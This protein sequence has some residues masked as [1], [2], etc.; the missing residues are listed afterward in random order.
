MR[1][2]RNIGIRPSKS[3][4]HSSS[5]QMSTNLKPSK[6]I[7]AN[8]LETA[9]NAEN[10]TF[11]LLPNL[12]TKSTNLQNSHST[13]LN[14]PFDNHNSANLLINTSKFSIGSRHYINKLSLFQLRR[15]I[16]I[17]PFA[18]SGESDRP[19]AIHVVQVIGSDGRVG[20]QGGANVSVSP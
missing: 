8:K 17:L 12:T 19:E 9:T 2:C 15:V 11:L 16:V 10:S 3:I 5:Q 20:L 18:G 1:S 13:Q 7:T 4:H 6:Q 14:F